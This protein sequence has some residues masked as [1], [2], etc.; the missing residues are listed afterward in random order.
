MEFSTETMAGA[1]AA[2][3]IAAQL[4]QME[5]T[6]EWVRTCIDEDLFAEAPFGMDDEAVASGMGKLDSWC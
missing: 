5:P 1:Q 6:E 2:F 4:V 3:G